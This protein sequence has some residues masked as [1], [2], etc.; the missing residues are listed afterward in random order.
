[1]TINIDKIEV[2][3]HDDV[4]VSELRPLLESIMSHLK[5]YEE[6]MEVFFTKLDERMVGVKED[7]TSLK[8]EIATLRQELSDPEDAATLDRITAKADAALAKLG[9]IDDMTP[10]PVPPQ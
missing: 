9:E 4:A 5:Q 2:H 8:N 1:M 10:P 3:V 6:K 7:V